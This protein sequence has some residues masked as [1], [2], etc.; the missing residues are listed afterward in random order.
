MFLSTGIFLPSMDQRALGWMLRPW[1][2]F[3]LRY[4]ILRGD[5]VIFAVVSCLR[6][7]ELLGELNIMVLVG[8]ELLGFYPH[9]FA[10]VLFIHSLHALVCNPG[11]RTA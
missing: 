1:W 5:H 11:V 8:K 2:G 3:Q 6:C 9:L 10:L 7:A 4:N